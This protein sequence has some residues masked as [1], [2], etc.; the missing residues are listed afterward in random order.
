MPRPLSPRLLR[1]GALFGLDPRRSDPPPPWRHDAA[2]RLDALLRPGQI[3]LLTGPSGAGKSAVLRALVARLRALRRRVRIAQ[4]PVA[5]GR[6]VVTLF[7]S[8]LGHTLG[9]LAR[10][11]LAEAPLILRRADRLSDGQRAR[12]AIALALERAPA[13]AT[14]I[15]DEFA[16]TLDRPTAHALAHSLRRL[17]TPDLSLRLVCA[18]AHDDL[19]EP[20]AP[21]VLVEFTAG[22][23]AAVH[24]RSAA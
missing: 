16:S 1:A 24:T 10:T 22:R 15:I 12:L 21:D 2:Q 14:V 6:A 8:S 7:R 23:P 17:M 20:L 13:G 4:P 3:A 19:L 11:G 5:R 9:L 18:T